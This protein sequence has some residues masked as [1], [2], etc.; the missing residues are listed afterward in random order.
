MSLLGIPVSPAAHAPRCFF[1]SCIACDT[2]A[3][4][5]CT[6]HT[7][8][9]SATCVG[10]AAHSAEQSKVYEFQRA[11]RTA[12]EKP[13]T[14]HMPALGLSCISLATDTFGGLLSS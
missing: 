4:S 8:R 1:S 2:T 5:L 12:L 7:I 9:H 14:L 6:A 13:V 10:E 11:V 3:R